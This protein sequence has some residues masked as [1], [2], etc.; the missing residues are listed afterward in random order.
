MI[1]FLLFIIAV[2]ATVLAV[3]LDAYKMHLKMLKNELYVAYSEIELLRNQ[4]NI[5]SALLRD[6]GKEATSDAV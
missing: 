2:L 4:L 5:Q 3:H 1:Y 6:E